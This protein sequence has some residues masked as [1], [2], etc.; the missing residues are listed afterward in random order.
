MPPARTID[1]PPLRRRL[2]LE[3]QPE[4]NAVRKF[5]A[6]GQWRTPGQFKRLATRNARYEVYSF[7]L[8][9]TNTSCILK[10]ARAA[11][12]AYRPLRRLGVLFSHL[13]RDPARRA[14]RG[15][16]LLARHG[17]PTFRPLACWKAR[18]NGWWR[19]SFLLYAGIPAR[20][21]LRNYKLGTTGLTPE[22]NARALAALTDQ[23]ADL[24]ASMHRQGLLHNDL[25]CGNFLVA[26]NGTL[27]AID[28]DHV[29]KSRLRWFP[30]LKRIFDLNDLR[31][32]DLDEPLRR[33]F[34]RRYLGGRDS[35]F[36]WRVHLFW[37]NGGNRPLRWLRRRLGLRRARAPRQTCPN[38]TT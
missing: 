17:V 1:A 35:E 24:V 8:A 15:A 18:G 11:P 3:D 29:R 34:L 36:W 12:A 16:R 38:N 2:I 19:D 33:A 14:L 37:R 30:R 6:S 23:F 31:R 27:H 4:A 20:H 25:A 32:M 21:S 26:D 22:E 9:D 7:P 13:T 10:I 28:A 5:I